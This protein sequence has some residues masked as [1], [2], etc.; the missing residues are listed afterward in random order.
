MGAEHKEKEKKYTQRIISFQIGSTNFRMNGQIYSMDIAPYIKDGSVYLPVRF[1]AL[2]MGVSEENILW[3]NSSQKLTIIKGN[4]VAQLIVG[5]NTIIING[6]SMKTDVI[7][8]TTLN[9]IM[10]PA[11]YIIEALGGTVSWDEDSETVLIKS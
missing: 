4:T 9:H 10:V 1:V 11:R 8:E 5:Q 6:V 3:D 7:P 2:A